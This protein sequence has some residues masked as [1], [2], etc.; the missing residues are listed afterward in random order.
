[1]NDI[2]ETPAEEEIEIEASWL[3]KVETYSPKSLPGSVSGVGSYTPGYP[4]YQHRS[5]FRP[6]YQ[7]PQTHLENRTGENG[8]KLSLQNDKQ[9]GMEDDVL[10]SEEIDKA[11][12]QYLA[13]AISLFEEQE[14]MEAIGDSGI[15]IPTKSRIAKQKEPAE[16]KAQPPQMSEGEFDYLASQYGVEA[17]KAKQTIDTALLELDNNDEALMDVIRVSFGLLSGAG[18]REIS[19][20]GIS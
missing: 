8:E 13:E 20:K 4:N 7:P 19:M 9:N 12:D 14:E 1:M 5:S 2:F 16:K 10:T 15:L 17:A 6:G 3:D 18:Q 11:W